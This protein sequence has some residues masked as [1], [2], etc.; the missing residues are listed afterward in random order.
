MVRFLGY[1]REVASRSV[2]RA[3]ITTMFSAV[4]G[5]TGEQPEAAWNFLRIRLLFPMRETKSPRC[6]AKNAP[7]IERPSPR[8]VTARNSTRG[9]GHA[10]KSGKVR[11]LPS[12]I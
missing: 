11:R 8:L 6:A 4:P 7:S 9:C 1:K 10:P 5:Q 2:W 12:R 3:A